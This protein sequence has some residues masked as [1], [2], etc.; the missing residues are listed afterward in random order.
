MEGPTPVSALIHSATMVTAGVYLLLRFS[1]VLEFFEDVLIFL[2][3]IGS[4]TAFFASSVGLVQNDIKK[5]VAYSTC[6]Q[7][8]YMMFA[9]GCSGYNM[10]FF[11]LFN[12]SFFK[13]LLFLGSGVLIHCMNGEQDVRK[14]GGLFYLLS[15][16][17]ICFFFGVMS[18]IGF[19]FFS[20]FYSK[21]F[22]VNNS[23]L[24]YSVSGL[25]SY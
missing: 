19:P 8:G 21:D 11:H 1:P 23:Y 20:G 10:A 4:L 12:H 17:F 6:S 14:F 16:I 25:F 5:V 18:L 22:I 15:F 7:L 2:I 13:A 3:F 9:I 24:L